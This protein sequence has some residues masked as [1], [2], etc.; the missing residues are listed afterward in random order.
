MVTA[1][2]REIHD[3]EVVFV[4]MRLP[5]IAFQLAKFTHAPAAVGVFENGIVRDTP[6]R[7]FL[8]TMGDPANVVGASMCTRMP[9]AMALLGR[10]RVDLGFIGGAE[11]DRFGNVNSSY[12][13]ARTHPRVKLPGSGGA[14]DIATL[15]RRLLVIMVHER[16][17]LRDA[18][19]YVTSPGF[20]RGR[21]QRRAAGLAG[22]GPAALIT[23]LGVFGFEAQTGE[24]VL[25]SYH[26]GVTVEQIRQQTGWTLRIAADVSETPTPTD[27]EVSVIRRLDPEGFWTR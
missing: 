1:A 21:E 18:V 19:D 12:I 8:L 10:G 6:S 2:A 26:P 4:G 16:H 3:G 22:G 15:A 27:E 14:C 9:V 13:G 24:A 23:T 7:E 11:I 17:R 5:L 25:R 20:L